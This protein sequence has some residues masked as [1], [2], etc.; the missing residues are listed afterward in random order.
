MPTVSGPGRYD[1]G[2]TPH[3][4]TF[5]P[6]RGLADVPI[7]DLADRLEHDWDRDATFEASIVWEVARRALAAAGQVAADR[8]GDTTTELTSE[9]DA[10]TLVTCVERAGEV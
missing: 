4:S 7:E 3:I 9:D 1:A 6:G 2:V 8:L 5:P 10:S